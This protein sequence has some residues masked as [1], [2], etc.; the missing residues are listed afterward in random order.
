MRV[1][2]Q[3]KNNLSRRNIAAKKAVAISLTFNEE[4]AIN[5]QSLIGITLK[6][7]RL[8]FCQRK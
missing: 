6:T 8:Y 3:Q 7:C 5:N 1:K 2:L 4:L